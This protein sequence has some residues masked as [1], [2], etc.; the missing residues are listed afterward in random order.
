MKTARGGNSPASRRGN[1]A[2]ARR[3]LIRR[4]VYTA[5]ATAAYQ[6]AALRL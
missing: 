2:S 6:E 3:A 5:G 4:G 1:E